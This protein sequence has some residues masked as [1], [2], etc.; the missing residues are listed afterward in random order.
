MTTE[1]LTRPERDKQI[2]A[3]Y[4]EGKTLEECG[5]RFKLTRQRVKQIVKQAGVYRKMEQPGKT[6]DRDAFLG[7]NVHPAVKEKLRVEADK[8]PEVRSVSDLC[9]TWLREKL[10]E[11]GHTFEVSAVASTGTRQADVVREQ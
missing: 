7:I 8:R 6:S 10:I 5:T 4:A 1:V 11:A 2:C 9:N 3:L